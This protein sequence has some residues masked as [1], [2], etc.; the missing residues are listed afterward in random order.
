TGASVETI[1]AGAPLVTGLWYSIT[2]TFDGTGRTVRLVQRALP[3]SY[4]SRLAFR[5]PSGAFDARSDAQFTA[6]LPATVGI[7]LTLAAWSQI[8]LGSGREVA[9]AFFNGKLDRPRI[10]SRAVAM[11]DAVA[12]VHNPTLVGDVLAAWDFGLNITSQGIRD[13]ATISDL[14]PNRRHG[15]LINMPMRGAT[16]HNW[17]STEHCYQHAPGQY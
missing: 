9:A 7:P 17:D 13:F 11:E 6:E 1:E 4:N 2:L 10:A 14:T 16:G 5:D 12:M 3:G 8:R 15:E